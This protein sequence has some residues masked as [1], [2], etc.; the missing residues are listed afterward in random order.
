MVLLA[1]AANSDC[2]KLYETI[3]ITP[4]DPEKVRKLI[5]GKHYFW[6]ER[7]LDATMSNSHLRYLYQMYP[8]NR[9]YGEGLDTIAVLDHKERA[10]HP[11]KE[12]M[13]SQ[14]RMS[15]HLASCYSHFKLRSFRNLMCPSSVLHI[16]RIRHQHRPA[17]QRPGSTGFMELSRSRRRSRS[18]RSETT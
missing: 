13:Y 18:S 3:G 11:K 17:L 12:Y 8:Q 2:R 5:M 10:K 14:E 15:G 7:G 4:A 1:A 6:K 9:I 16:S